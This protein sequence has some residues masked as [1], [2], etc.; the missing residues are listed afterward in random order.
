MT[1]NGVDGRG[2]PTSLGLSF[3]NDARLFIYVL[4]SDIDAWPSCTQSARG[5]TDTWIAGE[6]HHLSTGMDA[7]GSLVLFTDSV[8]ANPHRVAQDRA[9]LPAG[10]TGVSISDELGKV[11]TCRIWLSSDG[12]GPRPNPNATPIKLIPEGS[13]ATISPDVGLPLHTSSRWGRWTKGAATLR[14]LTLNVE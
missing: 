7:A 6:L 12:M 1:L 14:V 5:S 8:K 11:T 13:V 3:R 4:P 9:L 10:I 2:K